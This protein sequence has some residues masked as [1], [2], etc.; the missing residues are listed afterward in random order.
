MCKY[1]HTCH[2]PNCLF[3]IIDGVAF[4]TRNSL[5]TD[6][7]VLLLHCDLNTGRFSS[8]SVR[9]AVPSHQHLFLKR[10]IPDVPRSSR[11]RCL[12]Y[13]Q[14]IIWWVA[15]MV[16]NERYAALTSLGS[17]PVIVNFF[18]D[19]N[20]WLHHK[21]QL[22][23]WMYNDCRYAATVKACSFIFPKTCNRWA[24]GI[25]PGAPS[26]RRVCSHDRVVISLTCDWNIPCNWPSPGSSY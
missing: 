20:F 5:I 25:L 4:I 1:Y 18:M 24:M 3:S 7:F 17:A 21:K 12:R 14:S 26:R 6:S 10:L 2:N 13:Q 9:Q 15:N 11:R 23:P 16:T 19:D 8:G 22:L